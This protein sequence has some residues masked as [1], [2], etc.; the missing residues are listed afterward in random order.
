MLAAK[1]MYTLLHIPCV[2]IPRPIISGRKYYLL[3]LNI[4][5]M[6]I[7]KRLWC[8]V[9]CIIPVRCACKDMYIYMQLY[10]VPGI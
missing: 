2:K 6:Y 8:T 3:S 9:I 1:N 7:I 4:C 10:M 5:T